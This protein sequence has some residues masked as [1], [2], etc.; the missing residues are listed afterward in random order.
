VHILQCDTRVT[1]DEWI[2]VQNLDHYKIAGFGGSDMSP[3][4]NHL[5]L[6]SE[7]QAAMVITDGYIEYPD[8]PPAYDVLWVL[9]GDCPLT[10]H[11]GSV[12]HVIPY[13]G[14]QL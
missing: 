9:T 4:M 2:S 6:D 14:G 11:Y 12:L 1:V 13:A 3:A 5:N 10:P 8:T 7:V